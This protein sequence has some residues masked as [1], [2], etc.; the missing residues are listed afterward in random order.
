MPSIKY[1]YSASTFDSE[2]HITEL[3]REIREY[4]QQAPLQTPEDRE[5]LMSKLLRRAGT[6]AFRGASLRE[7]GPFGAL[8]VDFHTDDGIPQVVGF[9]TNHVVPTSDPSAHAEMT[10]IRNAAA[11]TGRTDLS[12]LTLITSCECCPMCL[13]AATGCK[14]EKI[15]FAATRADAAKVGFSDEDQYRLM[16][17]GGI[18][19]HGRKATPQDHAE[20]LLNG[21]D[22]AVEIRYKG[23]THYY[24]GDYQNANPNDPTDLPVI[25][26]IKHACSGLAALRGKESGVPEM[27]FHLPEDTRIISRDMPHPMSLITAD[28]ARIGRVRGANPENPA[29]DAQQKNTSQI[30]YLGDQVETMRVRKTADKATDM[31]PPERIWQEI[32]NPS[33]VHLDKNL[34]RAR[35][36]AFEKWDA[37]VNERAMP[38]Y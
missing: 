33:A 13:S 5:W 29:E 37:L 10:A 18:E 28:W 31:V 24:Y 32:R 20:A 4:C 27:V 15:Y 14:V 25:Q 21:H 30:L 19:Q 16:S 36:I 35:T 12:G 22:A 8:L 9:G 34:G 6:A 3:N 1:N 2:A 38:R 17:A 7:G 11:R 26:A 23:A